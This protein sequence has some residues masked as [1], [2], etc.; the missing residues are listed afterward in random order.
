MRLALTAIA[1]LLLS[2]P[3]AFAHRLDEYLQ[4]TILSVEKSGLML[5]SLSR[6]VL[7]YFRP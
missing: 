1:L 7:P 4:G 5:R 3:F 6:P 2:G